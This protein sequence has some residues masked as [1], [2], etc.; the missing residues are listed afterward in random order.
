MDPVQGGPCQG[1]RNAIPEMEKLGVRNEVV[2]LDSPS[3]PFLAEESLQIHA[4]GPGRRPWCYSGKLMPWLLENL[5][6]FD[7]VVVHGLW[8]YHGYAVLQAIKRLKKREGTSSGG[9]VKVPSLY[10]MPHGMLDPYFQRASGRRLKAVRNWFYWKLVESQVVNQADGVLFTCESELQLAREPFRPYQPKQ[11]INVG[12]GIAAPPLCRQSMQ[13][14]FALSCPKLK[15]KPYLLFLSRIHEKKGVELLVKAYSLALS[16]RQKSG[17]VPAVAGG[18]E[19]MEPVGAETDLPKLVIAGPGLETPYGQSLQNLVK[20]S[21][22]LQDAV[23]FPGMLTG[24][25]KWGA[26]YGCD[27]FVLPSHQEN[28]GIAV[29]EALSCG[30]PVLISNQVNIWREIENGGGGIVE[31]DTVA[32]TLHMLEVWQALSDSARSRM[33]L[34]ARDTFESCFAMEPAAQRF[35]NA[36]E[37]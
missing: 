4:L 9:K 10:V 15:G 12:Y 37:T 7:A 19:V 29:V 5:P 2:C 30:K 36:V 1:I 22:N 25:A 3:A 33:G 34:Q 17:P 26:F 14:A 27:A 23:F 18:E 32:G 31:E 21:P 16:K 24:E 6:R 8:L 35:L 11:E 20:E 28:F 13:E